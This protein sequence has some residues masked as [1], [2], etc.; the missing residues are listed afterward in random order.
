MIP[1]FIPVPR[2]LVVKQTIFLRSVEGTWWEHQLEGGVILPL[3]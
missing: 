2:A 3:E 1:V